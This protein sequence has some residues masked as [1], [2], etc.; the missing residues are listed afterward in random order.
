[1]SCDR[2]VKG[3]G[4]KR[5]S[6]EVRVCASARGSAHAHARSGGTG[7]GG[8]GRGNEAEEGAEQMRGEAQTKAQKKTTKREAILKSPQVSA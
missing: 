5:K 3:E 8:R 6:V 2:A 1:M 4:K 7:A